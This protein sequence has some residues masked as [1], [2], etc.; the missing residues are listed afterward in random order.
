MFLPDLILRIYYSLPNDRVFG[1]ISKLTNRVSAVIAKFILDLTLPKYFD[2][3]EKYYPNGLN[4]EVRSKR[5]V[6][7]L[8]SIPSRIDDLW[9]VIETLLRQKYKPDEILLWLSRDQF[10]GVVIPLK[11]LKQQER[12]LIIK[13]VDGDLKS[14]KKYIYAIK[15]F[16][17]DFIVTVD[18]D[19]YFDSRL[20]ENLISLKSKFPSSI[21]TNRSHRILFDECDIICP[22]RKWLHNSTN[23]RPSYFN[24]ATGG[25]GT[26]YSADDLSEFSGNESLI[27][28]LAPF[29]DDL[30]LKINSLLVD[31]S[32]VTNGVYNKNPIT[33]KNSQLENLFYGNVLNGGNDLQLKRLLEYFKIGDL[34]YFL[35]KEEKIFRN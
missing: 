14:H 7:S 3:T 11:L 19:L 31:K 34:T 13:F 20:L 9:L 12:G 33:V 17:S 35:I 18:D 24:I 2:L 6:V 28:E 29:G 16:T 8:T 10:E 5:V 27:F 30:W 32:V 26:L 15:A 25:N 21:P 4:T 22:Y 1:I 23:T